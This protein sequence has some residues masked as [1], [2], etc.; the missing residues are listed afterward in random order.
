VHS[1]VPYP[2]RASWKL[3]AA[4]AL[5]VLAVITPSASAK[6]TQATSSFYQLNGT[7]PVTGFTLSGYTGKNVYVGVQVT[8][9]ATVAVPTAQQTGLALP[10]GYSSFSGSQI[11][12]TGPATNAAA[13]LAALT[14][15]AGNV[16]YDAKGTTN[17]ISL[18]VTAFEQQ[19]GV[20]YNP[21]NQH[22]YKYVAGKITGT[23]ALA[24]G[25]ASTQ[26]GMT[27]Y[28]A[29]ITDAGENTFVAEKIQGDAG[30]P[31][32]NVWIG[33]T[34]SAEE[35]KWVWN[36]GP[37]NGV[38]FWQGCNPANGGAAFQGRFSAWASGEPNN[39]NASLCQ[40]ENSA[41]LG[42]DCA[43]INKYSPTSDPPNN[44]FFQG[45]WN[46]LP[47]SYGS[48]T[49]DF[50]AGYIIEYGN[51][52]VGG[53]FSGVDIISSSFKARPYV[54]AVKPNFFSK[55]FNLLFSSKFRKP[56]PKKPNKPA[57]FTFKTTMS[58]VNPGTYILSIKRKDGRGVP[59]VLLPGTKAQAA[60]SKDKRTLR[61]S[62]WSIQV[63]TTKANQRVT[64]EP[65]LKTQ[66]WL[67]P[68]GTKVSVK[69]KTDSNMRCPLGWCE[70]TPIPNPKNQGK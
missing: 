5:L 34:D 67:K 33:A 21:A 30:A 68:S 10:F 25:A 20:A 35:G 65:V 59:Y 55:V 66:D 41:T 19:A 48:G 43:I 2:L 29:S 50:V 56:L 22:F 42:E 60:G 40:S 47:C 24:A 45:Q 17:D 64:L 15:S 44:A 63:T 3:V 70:S 51:K 57:S 13:A 28:L 61:S 8:G 14:I 7:A 53:D 46:D 1:P 36:G 49:N 37:D 38:Q 16:P 12:F 52:A 32:K 6:V 39:W 26:L 18:T 54:K 69:L 4:A 58:F 27:G 9:A 23:D 11:A 31:A 62:A